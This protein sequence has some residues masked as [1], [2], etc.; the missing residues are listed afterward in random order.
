VG[1]SSGAPRWDTL[2]AAYDLLLRLAAVSA[3]ESQAAV[4]S[5]LGWIEFAR[6]RGSLA[7][8]YLERAERAC[9]GY[10]LAGLLKELILRG[11]LPDWACSPDTAWSARPGHAG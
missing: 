7:C 3:G 8:V 2:D 5:M 4:H 11:G 10:R 6:G 9:P 1:R